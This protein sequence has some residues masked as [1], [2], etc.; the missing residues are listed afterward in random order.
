MN[1]S[2]SYNII[3][4]EN[5]TRQ[6]HKNYNVKLGE[7]IDRETFIKIYEEAIK[8]GNPR[9]MTDIFNILIKF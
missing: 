2:V 7:N 9:A 1:Q 8:E 6:I 3:Y 5:N 4:S